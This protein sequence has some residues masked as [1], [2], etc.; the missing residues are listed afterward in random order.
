M[1]QVSFD[2]V[3]RATARQPAFW[4]GAAP[5][6][7][8]VHCMAMPAVV[9]AA[10]ALAPARTLEPWL[11]GV[12]AVLAVI[13]THGGVRVHGRRGVWLPLAAGLAFWA[14]GFVGWLEPL[15]ELVPVLLGSLLLAG[16]LFRNAWLRHRALC[17]RCGCPAH[18]ED[19]A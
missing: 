3:V 19:R 9:L 2:R 10:P 12:S 11:L 18:V 15:P 7:C 8:A 17:R 4:V 14:I 6:L 16:G 13:F 1:E 5:L